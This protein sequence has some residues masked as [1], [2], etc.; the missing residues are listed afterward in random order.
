MRHNYGK[1][2]YFQRYRPFFE[3]VY[4]E[5]KWRSLCELNRYLIQQ[6]GREFLGIST[7]FA[8]DRQYH[9]SDAKQELIIDLATKA[10]ATC[11]ISG[12]S[13]KNYIEEARFAQ[14]GMELIWKDYSG[15][16]EYPQ[17]HPP[18]EHGV[19]ILDLL[20]HTGPEA[21]YYIWGWRDNNTDF[22]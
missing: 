13:A 21:P 10:G 7:V 15:Y 12:P 5:R 17:F 3:D 9:T 19:T 2:P 1:A 18:F 4:L 20:F 11:Y 16:P 22:R 6:I 14:I 8:D